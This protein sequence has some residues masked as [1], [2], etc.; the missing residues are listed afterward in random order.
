MIDIYVNGVIIYMQISQFSQRQF[1]IC[2]FTG[3]NGRDGTNGRN[4]RDGGQGPKGIA[5]IYQVTTIRQLFTEVEANSDA[6]F[7]SHE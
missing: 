3:A 7:P 4:G 1:L 6:N 2:W 5:T